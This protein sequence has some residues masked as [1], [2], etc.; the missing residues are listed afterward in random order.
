MKKQLKFE[1]LNR[2]KKKYIVS[3]FNALI[4]IGENFMP[5]RWYKIAMKSHDRQSLNEQVNSLG[6]HSVFQKFIFVK[7]TTAPATDLNRIEFTC[8]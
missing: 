7:S 8:P 1:Y 5:I 6:Q 4:N 2:F 3:I